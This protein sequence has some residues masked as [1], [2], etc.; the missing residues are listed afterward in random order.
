MD[1]L[2][3]IL[4]PLVIILIAFAAIVVAVA[5][6]NRG[7]QLKCPKCGQV[8]KAPLMDDK[9]VVGV[10]LPYL[11]QVK[12]P[13]CGTSRSRGEYQKVKKASTAAEPKQVETQP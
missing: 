6:L 8:F 12:C 11:G 7:K 4:N 5:L 1:A 10:T 3:I 9:F 13:H 2:E